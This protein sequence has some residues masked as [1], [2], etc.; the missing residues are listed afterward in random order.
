MGHIVAVMFEG[1]A[2]FAH[3]LID[4]APERMFHFMSGLVLIA[5][6]LR[7]RRTFE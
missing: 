4:P 3:Q 5:V 7:L 2:R 1:L 6:G